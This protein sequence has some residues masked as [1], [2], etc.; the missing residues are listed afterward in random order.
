MEH[1]PKHQ[2]EIMQQ[3]DSSQT[4]ENKMKKFLTYSL[5]LIVLMG[6][7]LPNSRVDAQQ[8]G[9]A[10]TTPGGLPGTTQ[11]S[12]NGGTFCAANDQAAAAE[13]R[14]NSEFIDLVGKVASGDIPGSSS[15]LLDFGGD[16]S[17]VTGNWIDCIGNLLARIAWI[18]MTIMSWLLW[19]AG[20]LLNYVIKETVLTMKEG[21]DKMTGINIGWKVIR[22]VMNIAFIFLLVY[23]GIMMIIGQNGKD[24]V[25]KYIFSIVLAALLINFSL[26]FTKVLIDASNVVTIGLY[27]S[28]IDSSSKATVPGS[29]GTS[30]V[31]QRPV[32]GLSAPFMNALSLQEL[33]GGNSF[34]NIS[35]AV[36][37]GTNML[38]FFLMGA[39][40]FLIM[41]F[42]FFAI[43]MMFIIR[44]ITLLIL[45]MTSPIA[46]MGS[47]IPGMS[48]YSKQWWESLKGQLLFAP[49]Y[50][51]ITMI[52]LKLIESENFIKT[53]GADWSG[54][55]MGTATTAVASANSAASSTNSTMSL[56][57]NFA[58]IV[59]LAIASLVIAK[60]SA[61]KGSGYIK[62][63]TG[64]LTAFAGGAVMGG[65]AALS[66]RTFG[67]GASRL[68]ENQNFQNWAGR[69]FVGE[70]LLNTTRKVG[71][72]SLDIR[73][74][75][76]GES[77]AKQIG[78]DF[79]KGLPFKEDAGQGGFTRT[80]TEKA[81]K[82]EDYS[83]TLRGDQAKRDFAIRK[84][85]K[86]HVRQ[87]SRSNALTVFGTMGRGNR[88]ASAKILRAQVDP[89]ETQLQN[90]NNT[91][92]NQQN[93]DSQL[94]QQFSNLNNEL[95]TL[96][97]LPTPNPQQTARL[98]QLNGPAG[99]AGSMAN[100]Q[101]QIT[102][103]NT[104]IANTQAQIGIIN[105]QVANL[106]AEIDRLG[107]NNT[108]NRM[109][110]TPQQQAQH[111]AAVAAAA[112]AGLPPPP[113]PQGR[114]VRADEQNY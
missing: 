44:Y 55:V 48:T 45:L 6:I 40:L 49:I 13:Q 60:S 18:I 5:I 39:I 46:Y 90:L 29:N 12:R 96:S 14:E 71:G 33:Y 78:T 20:V 85:D 108:A 57:L 25:K 102:A 17:F 109:P 36:G 89:L 66:R 80:V 97:A 35:K 41:A 21:V 56:I 27:N 77:V 61:T 106:N 113:P 82:Q 112:A 83:R 26:F 58:V 100:I 31:T 38:I 88:I 63:A 75:S 47:A 65:T 54:L 16:C 99:T 67:A 110:L 32:E 24:K 52:V 59:G 9:D 104:N 50:M 69:S 79:G 95:N 92:Q 19:L 105:P 1:S 7:I 114:P 30:D 68:A 107:L 28:M 53:E 93:R 64:K 8:I 87:G 11:P 10:C 37:G 23:E 98:A 70:K 74:S 103:N 2:A 42:V 81:K 4:L 3:Q 72:G 15:A 34:D 73:R 62:D 94:N 22:D 86:W 91:L 84:A 76:V 43:A 51:L 101:A 111:N